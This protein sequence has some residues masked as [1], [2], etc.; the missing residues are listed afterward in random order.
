[1]RNIELKARLHDRTFAEGAC[2]RIG[3]TPQGDIRQTDTYFA[4]PTGRL[5]LRECD[6]GEDYLVFYHRTDEAAA[7]GSD[8]VIER[9]GASMGGLLKRSLGVSGVVQKTRTLWLW[10]NVRVHLD[11]VEGLGDFIEFEAVLSEG[12]D[13]A[14]GFEKLAYL[15]EAFGVRDDDIETGSYLDLLQTTGHAQDQSNVVV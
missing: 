5:K 3:A 14:D 9:V 4:V 10:K 11:R 13:D 1:M 7:R 12:L 6:P 8:Y 2:A 15:R